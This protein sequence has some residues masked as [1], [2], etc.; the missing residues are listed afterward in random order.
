MPRAQILEALA[1]Y[2]GG[3]I[4]VATLG[5][6]PAAGAE[7]S[8]TVPG[9][10]MW[11]VHSVV[12]QLDTDGTAANRV[13]RFD[14]AYGGR[15]IYSVAST[16]AATADTIVNFAAGEGCDHGG[17]V[18]AGAVTM[19]L[20]PLLLQPGATFATVTDAIVAGDNWAAPVLYVTEIPERGPDVWAELIAALRAELS[21]RAGM[22]I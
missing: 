14:F 21:A 11:R 5:D 15:T 3:R 8:V 4:L 10:A 22:G 9:R 13:P 17:S 7:V 16:V 12:A 1:G 6:D 18:A 19:P 2:P 20:P